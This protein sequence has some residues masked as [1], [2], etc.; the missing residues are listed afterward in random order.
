MK[1]QLIPICPAQYYFSKIKEQCV[2]IPSC[3][4]YEYF[5]MHM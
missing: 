4:D 2:S 5:N 3:K 1:C